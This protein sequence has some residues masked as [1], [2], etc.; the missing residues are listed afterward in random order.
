VVAGCRVTEGTLK[1]SLTF[2]VMRGGEMVHEGPVASLRRHKL[3][4]P[5][6]GKGTEC[7]VCLDGFSDVR[8]GDSLQCIA[9]EAVKRQAGQGSE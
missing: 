5:A 7:G 6:V 8:L 4:V 3:E 2:R 1:G 9:M